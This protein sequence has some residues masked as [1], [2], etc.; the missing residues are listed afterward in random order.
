MTLSNF[1]VAYAER[2]YSALLSLYPARF[3]IQFAAEMVQLFRDCCHDALEKGEV[4]VLVAF[5]LR[6]AAD[7]CTSAFHE[8][9]KQLVG[10]LNDEHPLIGIVDLLL[11]PSMVTA[12][13]L[14]LG[15]ILTLLLQ[16][17]VMLPVDQ[18]AAVSL[19]FSFTIGG[20]AVAASIVITKLRP[21]VRLWVKLS[22]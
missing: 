22:A 17:G 6:A 1:T 2:A 13:L 14:A 9:R 8:R 15:P 20:L 10:P 19:F 3:R 7:L 11:I 21:T 18:F 5:W 16:H 12:N 4:A